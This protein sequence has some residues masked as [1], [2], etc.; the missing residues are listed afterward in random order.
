MCD[1]NFLLHVVGNKI[2]TDL[3]MR[4]VIFQIYTFN[5]AT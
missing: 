3:K 2:K 4:T 1:N 5:L